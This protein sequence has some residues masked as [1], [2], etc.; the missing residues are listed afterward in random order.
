[1]KDVLVTVVEHPHYLKKAEKLLSADQI[2]EIANMV[3]IN[4]KIGA[5]M[6]G[7]DG[8]RKFR[9]AGVKGKGKSGGMRIIHLFVADDGEVHLIDIF[10]KADKENLSKTEQNELAKLAALLKGENS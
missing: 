1:M 4:P 8:F 5:V 7:T 2:D 9:Y 3:A 10:E 6:C